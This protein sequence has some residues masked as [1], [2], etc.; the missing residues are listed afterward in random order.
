[1]PGAPQCSS[2]PAPELRVVFGSVSREIVDERALR[3]V[4]SI[5]TQVSVNSSGLG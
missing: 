1:V 3:D 4:S 5:G 2:C